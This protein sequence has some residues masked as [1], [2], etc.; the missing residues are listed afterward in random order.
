MLR[1]LKIFPFCTNQFHYLKKQKNFV[2][3]I[4]LNHKEICLTLLIETNFLEDGN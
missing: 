1:L 2:Y 3:K 4:K